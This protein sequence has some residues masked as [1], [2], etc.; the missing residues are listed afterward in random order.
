MTQQQWIES[1]VNEVRGQKAGLDQ[2]AQELLKDRA[3]IEELYKGA[4]GKMDQVESLIQGMNGGNIG[5]N[6]EWIGKVEAK[7]NQIEMNIQN[8]GIGSGMEQGYGFQHNGTNNGG[9]KRPILT[10]KA[11]L[12]LPSLGEGKGMYHSWSKDLRNTLD[13]LRPGMAQILSWI[14]GLKNGNDMNKSSWN[15]SVIKG[16]V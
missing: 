2:V 10:E 3:A 16:G 8:N 1:T 15:E 9:G 12:D 7:I 11:I 5:T 13:N 6:P 14:E 4:N